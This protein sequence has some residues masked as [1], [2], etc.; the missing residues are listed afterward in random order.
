LTAENI[1]LKHYLPYIKQLPDSRELSK[2]HL[3]NANFLMEK[4]GNLKM[5][6]APHNEYI[7]RHAKI[8]I[9]GITPGWTQ[10]RIAYQQARVSLQRGGSIEQIMKNTKRAA[11]FAG[12]MRTNLI[13]MLDACGVNDVFQ[14]SSCRLLFD[15]YQHLLHTTSVIKYPVFIHGKNYTGYTPKVFQSTILTKYAN[16]IFSKELEKIKG[17]YLLIPLGKAVTEIIEALV[18]SKQVPGEYCLFGFPHPSGA[19]GHRKKQFQQAKSG[20]V[21]VVQHYRK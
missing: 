8:V 10:M 6:Y 19:N 12:T 21:Q 17:D 7:N 4:S 5:Y 2:S 13:E 16:H 18:E 11:G 3:I 9:V 14:L 20:L 1:R 15:G